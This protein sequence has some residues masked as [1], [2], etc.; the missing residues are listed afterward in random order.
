MDPDQLRK[1]PKMDLLL[2]LPALEDSGLPRGVLRRAASEELDALR[3]GSGSVPAMETLAQSVLHR[4]LRAMEPGLARVVNA[5]GVVLHTNLGRAP[6]AEAAMNAWA[7]AAGYCDLE[8]DLGTGHRG[9]RGRA[10]PALLRDLTGAEDAAVVNNNAAAI[11][12]ALTAL[13]AGKGVA[14]SRGE[15]VEIGGSFRLPDIMAQSGAKLAEVGTTNRTRPADYRSAVEEGKAQVL[16]K[17]HTSN[18]R[19]V[20]YTQEVSLAELVGLGRAYGLPVLYDLGAGLLLPPRQFGLPK[21]AASVAE[22]LRAGADLVCFSGDKLLGGPQAGILAGRKW[23][24]DAVRNHPLFRALRP[25][26]GTLAALDATLRLYQDPEEAR[27]AIPVLSMLSADPEALACRAEALAQALR[28]DCGGRCAVSVVAGESE[29]GGGALPGVVFP[30]SLVTLVPRDVTPEVLE[31]A[32]RAAP[33]PVVA[34]LRHGRVALDVRTL[35]PGDD[36]AVC[37]AVSGG[38]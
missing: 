8:Y 26:K 38:V 16:L 27:R 7:G 11:L 33:V 32:L 30:T 4:A 25:D 29:A 18:Y 28:A 12:L 1:L 6:L 13:A 17:V 20:G 23:A 34:L 35:R 14:I 19:V 24:V 36:E 21:G 9:G 5:T 10:L 31:A 22:S 3:G 15:M 2:A 37:R